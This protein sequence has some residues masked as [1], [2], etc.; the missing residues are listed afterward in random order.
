L[1][2]VAGYFTGGGATSRDLNDRER[3][4]EIDQA[5]ICGS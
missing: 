1:A 5:F 2:D 4:L 3:N